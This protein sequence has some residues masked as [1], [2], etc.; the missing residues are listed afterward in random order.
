VQQSNP[1]STDPARLIGPGLAIVAAT[2]GLAR[3]C[4][5]LYLPEFEREFGI[6]P[7]LLG[8]IA[9]GSY[10]S[11]IGAAVLA[12]WMSGRTGPRLPVVLGGFAA[13]IGMA[14]IT[15][16]ETPVTLALGVIIAGASPGFAYPPLSDAVVRMIEPARQNRTY[17]IINSG[18]S[19]GVLVAAPI[20]LLAG[21]QWRAAWAIFVAVAVLA[22]FWNGRVLP[23]GPF[24]CRG[25]GLPK[26]RLDWYL[27]PKSFRLF[28]AALVL[29]LTTAVYWTFAVEMITIAV[30]GNQH[31]GQIFWAVLG[32]AGFGG[33]I[34]GDLVSRLGLRFG[35]RLGG[36]AISASMALLAVAP[37]SLPGM[38][39]SA[40]LFGMT[41]ILI[42]GMLGVW[43][44]NVFEDRPAAGFGATFLVITL[45]QMIGP[46]ISGTGA[47]V[48]GLPSMFLISAAAAVL[49][50]FLVPLEDIR[51]MSA[52]PRAA[53]VEQDTAVS[54]GPASV[55]RPASVTVFDL[56]PVTAGGM[57]SDD[58]A[59]TSGAQRWD[60]RER[61]APGVDETYVKVNR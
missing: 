48:I 44:I 25:E 22:A 18:T 29:G 15:L 23:S 59:E 28:A 32:L 52:D 2:Y 40:A 7:A 20:A 10:A 35:L 39:L 42:T 27:K 41:F 49:T 55:N 56:H 36:F 46:A 11:Y 3:Y 12:S 4:F 19:L 14:V 21:D 57:I 9:S 8:W 53:A 45:G 24:P 6:G 13:A 1:V 60:R 61:V 31:L 30:T 37:A 33:A 54:T 17:T 51:A 34:A 38:M 47:A 43:S 16:A 5:G 58:Q 50:V 26:L